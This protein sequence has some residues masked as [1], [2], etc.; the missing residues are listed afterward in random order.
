MVKDQHR[1]TTQAFLDNAANL[2]E[3]KLTQSQ[4]ALTYAA[5]AGHQRR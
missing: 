1:L 2:T 3:L 4:P 5:S